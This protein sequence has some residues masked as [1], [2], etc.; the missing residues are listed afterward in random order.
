MSKHPDHGNPARPGMSIP[1]ELAV[2]LGTDE[3]TRRFREAPVYRKTAVVP[4]R[5]AIPGEPVTTV[6]ADGL[7]E[8]AVTCVGGEP[9]ITNPGGEQ[10]VPMG[11]WE[12][13]TRRYDDIGGGLYQAKGLIR[14]I[15]NPTGQ[16]VTI[17]AP[18]GVQQRQGPDCLFAVEYLPNAPG[19]I[20][21]DRYLIG[22]GEFRQTYVPAV[23]NEGGP[24]A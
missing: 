10:Y 21:P 23:I 5:T 15:P 4:I 6:M 17:D 7:T 1:A 8:T 24:N 16:P 14:A 13:V 22:A 19:E 9:V 12:Q 3:M 2:D 18:W 20:G 11:G